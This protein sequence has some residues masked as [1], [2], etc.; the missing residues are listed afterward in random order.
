MGDAVSFTGAH[1]DPHRRRDRYGEPP[2]AEVVDAPTEGSEA[3]ETGDFLIGLQRVR[4]LGRQ[5]AETYR[6]QP[7]PEDGRFV[8]WPPEVLDTLAPGPGSAD[9]PAVAAGTDEPGG[10]ADAA[11]PEPA[12]RPVAN[13]PAP[14]PAPVSASGYRK[15]VPV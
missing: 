14:A 9:G 3:A 1:G 2:K 11:L 8:D 15:I 6:D 7:T 10:A 13:E 12:R 5:A 4:Y